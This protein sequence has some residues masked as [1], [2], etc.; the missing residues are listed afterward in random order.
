MKTARKENLWI[1]GLGVTSFGLTRI[2]YSPWVRAD[3]ILLYDAVEEHDA[4]ATLSPMSGA[5]VLTG[6]PGTGERVLST[7]NA[8]SKLVA[9]QTQP[10]V[11]SSVTHF[12]DSA[13]RESCSCG[14]GV[15]S[16]IFS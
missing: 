8:S 11:Y 2:Y 1:M 5:V 14:F 12:T 7:L 9:F 4:E 15:V 6:Q 13:R 3:Y 10:K 16:I